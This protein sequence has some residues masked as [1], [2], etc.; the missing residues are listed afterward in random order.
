MTKKKDPQEKNK[1]KLNIT[2]TF[3]LYG[4]YSGN[5]SKLPEMTQVATVNTTSSSR[6]KKGVGGGGQLWEVISKWTTKNC[7][8]GRQIWPGTFTLGQFLVI[9]SCLLS[10]T[11]GRFTNGDFLYECKFLLEKANFYSVQSLSCIC[12]GLKI[13][14][15]KY[16]LLKPNRKVLR[17]YILFLSNP[18]T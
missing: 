11:E 18:G 4:W 13:I 6:H 17:W 9:Y 10:G 12:H 2:H 7:R 14:S 16:I 5:L 3:C 1:L 8:A 15:S